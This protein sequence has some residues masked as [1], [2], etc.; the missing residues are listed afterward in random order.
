[1][2]RK[3]C[4]VLHT[5]SFLSKV[6]N[7]FCNL[8]ML[9]LYGKTKLICFKREW[10][11][12]KFYNPDIPYLFS[13]HL[14]TFILKYSQTYRCFKNNRPLSPLY[15]DLLISSSADIHMLAVP[16]R[17]SCRCNSCVSYMPRNSYKLYINWML[18]LYKDIL[19]N[20]GTVIKIQGI[21]Y[22]LM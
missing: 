18:F 1:M 22:Y 7:S 4:S 10:N 5:I 17:V 16:V 2:L 12:L 11:A 8:K 21:W 3:S 19:C 20:H 6:K 15:L 9:Q 14:K 13:L